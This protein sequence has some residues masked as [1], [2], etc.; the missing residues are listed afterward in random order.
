MKIVSRVKSVP[1]KAKSRAKSLLL[2]PGRPVANEKIERR[3]LLL[4]TALG[5]FA[6]Q[7]IAGTSLNDIAKQAK[8]TPALVHYY[9][10]NKDQLIEAMIAECFMPIVSQ[11]NQLLDGK[12]KDPLVT[13]M[14]ATQ[15]MLEITASIPWLSALWVREVLSEGGHLRDWMQEY[16]V[17]ELSEKIGRLTM[18]AQKKGQLN[19]KL[20]PRLMIVSMIGLTLFPLA[21]ASIWRNV[22][23]NKNISTDELGRHMLELLTH[24]IEVKNAAHE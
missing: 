5:L 10:G 11:F 2:R 18:A 12:N 1:D 3:Q 20:D 23:G 14:T 16:V 24:G 9:F 8:V 19:K 4:D 13:I 17:Q 7:G 21:G 22:P 15:Q 6:S